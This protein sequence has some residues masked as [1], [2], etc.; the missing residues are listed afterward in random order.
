MISKKRPAKELPTEGPS[1]AAESQ[2]LFIA[3]ATTLTTHI[4][5]TSH[6]H[7]STESHA[8]AIDARRCEGLAGQP[9]TQAEVSEPNTATPNLQ[10][11]SSQEQ[12][13]HNQDQHREA[14]AQEDQH[15]DSEDEMEAVI[16]D[17]LARFRQENERLRLV[18]EHMAKE[19]VVMKTAQITQQQIEQESNTSR[20]AASHRCSLSQRARTPNARACIATASAAA[21]PT[22]SPAMATTPSSAR[23]HQQ[24]VSASRQFAASPMA[25]LVQCSTST[26]ISGRF[27]LMQVPH[28]LRSHNSFIAGK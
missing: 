4:P 25:T 2:D 14:K 1:Q 10:P 5:Q 7:T 6:P 9:L 20:V 19:R 22:T 21:R 12:Q 24:Q 16:E 26:E 13:H 8:V 23:H 11:S 27:R 17:E 28:A 18:Q 15:Q 3:K